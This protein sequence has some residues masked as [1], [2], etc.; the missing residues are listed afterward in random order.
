MRP[1]RS[2]TTRPARAGT[3]DSERAMATLVAIGYPDETTA[4]DAAQTVKHLEET[5]VLAPGALAEVRRDADGKVHVE[6]SDK[7][8]TSETMWG[9]FWGLLFGMLFTIPVLG[10][11]VGAGL[12]L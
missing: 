5:R 8:K 10:L 3:E 2:R 11:A 12:G 6:T 7:A 9:A 4:H 1:R